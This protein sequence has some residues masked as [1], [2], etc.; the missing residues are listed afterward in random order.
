MADLSPAA[1]TQFFQNLH[2]ETDK[3]ACD[4]A[5][6]VC[7]DAWATAGVPNLRFVE[8]REILKQAIRDRLRLM[9][10]AIRNNKKFPEGRTVGIV[11]EF[12]KNFRNK[13]GS[14]SEPRQQQSQEVVKELAGPSMDPTPISRSSEPMTPIGHYQSDSVTFWQT[15]TLSRPKHRWATGSMPQSFV[16]AFSKKTCNRKAI[17]ESRARIRGSVHILWINWPASG[18]QRR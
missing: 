3:Q 16:F 18:W 13:L 15:Q 7:R 10:K 17:S 8:D 9:P 4:S 1:L 6:D 14:G 2:I 12:T 5:L 11:Y